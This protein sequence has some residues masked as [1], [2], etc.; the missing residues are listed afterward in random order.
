MT[1]WT[2]DFYVVCSLL[3]FL[4]FLLSVSSPASFPTVLDSPSHPSFLHFNDGIP[5]PEYRRYH[6]QTKP[7]IFLFFFFCP[8]TDHH[9]FF[10]FL[11]QLTPLVFQNKSST[12]TSNGQP[13]PPPFL[14]SSPSSPFSCFLPLPYSTHLS[15][16]CLPSTATLHSWPTS[17]PN[18]PRQTRRKKFTPSPHATCPRP[19]RLPPST[20]TP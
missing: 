6:Q 20:G 2:V 19:P 3:S 4:L 11:H 10:L 1:R 8:H 13:P 14:P 7:S 12:I 15:V 17:P 5:H 18:P 9:P 16:E